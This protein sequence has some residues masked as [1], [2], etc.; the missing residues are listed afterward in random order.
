MLQTGY[1]TLRLD[2]DHLRYDYPNNEVRLTFAS[3]LLKSFGR[4]QYGRVNRPVLRLGG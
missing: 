1:L 3:S 2:R 4:C